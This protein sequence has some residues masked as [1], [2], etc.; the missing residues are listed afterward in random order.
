MSL[1]Q[2]CQSQLHTYSDL[3]YV[4]VEVS[5]VLTSSSIK[6]KITRSIR[7]MEWTTLLRSFIR[8]WGF[9]LIEMGIDDLRNW[10]GT[11]DKDLGD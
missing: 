1:K 4:E 3:A 2:V 11:G 7:G 6:M 5:Q 9:E 8:Y 10:F